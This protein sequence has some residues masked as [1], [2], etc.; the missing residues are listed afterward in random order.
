[1]WRLTTARS[2]PMETR[3]HSDFHP[4]LEYAAQRVLHAVTPVKHRWISELFAA[5]AHVAGNT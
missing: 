2:F 3:L 4:V 1:M 5:P